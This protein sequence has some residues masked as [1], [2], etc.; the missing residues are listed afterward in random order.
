V[1]GYTD[2]TVLIDV[3]AGGFGWFIDP[4]PADNTEFV[5]TSGSSYLTAPAGSPAAGRMDLLT[6][7]MHELGH[8][9]G[10]EDLPANADAHD[11]MATTLVPGERR[12]LGLSER[13]LVPDVREAV[14]APVPTNRDHFRDLVGTEL[15]SAHPAPGQGSAVVPTSLSVVSGAILEGRLAETRSL[16]GFSPRDLALAAVV[17]GQRPDGQVAGQPETRRSRASPESAHRQIIDTVFTEFWRAEPFVLPEEGPAL[18]G[19]RNMLPAG[20]DDEMVTE[21]AR[22]WE[23]RRAAR[24]L[25]G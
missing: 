9:F 17:P 13:P 6:V 5:S 11:L 14:A 7:V 4:T 20:W 23:D 2:G 1:I 21:V 24:W 12:L 22:F 25:Q 15:V 3:N 18:A 16:P 8:V 19:G 10:L